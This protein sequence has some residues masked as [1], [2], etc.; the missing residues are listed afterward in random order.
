M[1]NGGIHMENVKL[2]KVYEEPVEVFALYG[3]VK[4]DGFK[5]FPDHNAPNHE[6]LKNTHHRMYKKY[7]KGIPISRIL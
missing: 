1:T 5:R 2:Y 6:H 4:A 3:N 7:A